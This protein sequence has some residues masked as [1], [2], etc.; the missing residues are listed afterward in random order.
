MQRTKS[1]AIILILLPLFLGCSLARKM[2]RGK[3][4]PQVYMEKLNFT[5]AKGIILVP[6]EFEG[7]VKNYLFDSG[8]Q[9]TG[10]QRTETK[11]RRVTVR[12]ASNR[13]IESGTEVLKSFKIGAVDFQKTF[14]HQ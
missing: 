7:V 10:I 13:T 5:T 1:F 6:C 8:S 9:L 12:G 11:G 3:V 4:A 14:R 2:Q